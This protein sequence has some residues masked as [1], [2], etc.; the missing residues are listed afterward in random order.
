VTAIFRLETP[1]APADSPDPITEE[2]TM[3]SN[4]IGTPR[5]ITACATM[6]PGTSAAMERRTPSSEYSRATAP[7]RGTPTRSGTSSRHNMVAVAK[8]IEPDT[9]ATIAQNDPIR[10]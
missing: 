8:A 10:R 5:V 1:A 2:M 6:N 4:E 9:G 3:L 7:S